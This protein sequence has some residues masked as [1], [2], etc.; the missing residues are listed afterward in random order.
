MASTVVKVRIVYL[1]S[2]EVESPTSATIYR[3][4]REDS[5]VRGVLTCILSIIHLVTGRTKI[6]KVLEEVNAPSA[7]QRRAIRITSLPAS[8]IA[9]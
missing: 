7:T 8:L 3:R 6:R 2:R 5:R 1:Q 4:L 9:N